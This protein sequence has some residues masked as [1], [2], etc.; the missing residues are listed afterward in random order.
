MMKPISA[1]VVT[2]ALGATLVAQQKP[3]AFTPIP[4]PENVAK[5]PATAS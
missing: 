4:A 2:I 1:L 3:P 5:P